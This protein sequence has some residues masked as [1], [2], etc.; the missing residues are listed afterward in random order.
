M[1]TAEVETYA[2]SQA[3]ILLDDMAARLSAHRGVAATYVTSTPAGPGGA[4]RD[5]RLCGTTLAESGATMCEWSN[6][7]K[8]NTELLGGAAVGAMIGGRG[9]I[10]PLG[11]ATRQAIE[12]RWPGRA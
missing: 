3:L 7:L 5:N 10:E 12:S 1:Q 9:C 4:R 8:G 2:R 6:S 11:G